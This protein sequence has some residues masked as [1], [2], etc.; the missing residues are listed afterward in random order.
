MEQILNKFLIVNKWIGRAKEG[1]TYAVLGT[2]HAHAR[3]VFEP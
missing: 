3:R 1:F 2:N